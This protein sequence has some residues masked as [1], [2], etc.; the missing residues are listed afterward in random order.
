MD[1][2]DQ[3]IHKVRDFKQSEQTQALEGCLLA[4]QVGLDML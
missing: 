1:H 3:I 2:C 4:E